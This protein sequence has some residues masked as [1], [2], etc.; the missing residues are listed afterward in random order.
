[1]RNIVFL[2]RADPE[3]SEF[4]FWLALQFAREGYPVWFDLTKLLGGEDFSR[5]IEKTIRERAQKF[6]YV[7][8]QRVN[9]SLQLKTQTF[10]FAFHVSLLYFICH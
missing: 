8:N 4:T 6:L 10:A 7:C 9:V 2:S 1:M 5:D 3:D